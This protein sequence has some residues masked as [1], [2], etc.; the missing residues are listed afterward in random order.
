MNHASGVP[1]IRQPRGDGAD[2]FDDRVLFYLQNRDVIDEWA[3]LRREATAATNRWLETLAAQIEE[4]RSQWKPWT[5][6][7]SDYRMLLLCPASSARE[8][9]L[10][11][12]G[13]GLGWK[14]NSVQPNKP[15]YDTG[16]SVGLRVDRNERIAS[17]LMS[18]LD[19]H[20][21]KRGS[22]AYESSA[23]WP[24]W[25]YVLG[26]REWW[27]DLDTYREQLLEEVASFLGRYAD[28]VEQVVR[29]TD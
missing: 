3:G 8:G 6:T 16:L 2:L 19:L 9:Q 29:G 15:G 7:V 17:L 1:E 24:R 27:L 12:V 10:P 5:G 11:T 25:R 21:P 23:P 13:I 22:G 26:S 20:D 14:V 4:L 18:A 28:L